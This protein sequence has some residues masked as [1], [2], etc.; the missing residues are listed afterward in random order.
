M[1]SRQE[2][3]TKAAATV[4]ELAAA[5]ARLGKFATKIANNFVHFVAVLPPLVAAHSSSHL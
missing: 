4:H 1:V 2:P 3:M 5:R